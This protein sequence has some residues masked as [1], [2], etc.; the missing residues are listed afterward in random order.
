MSKVFLREKKISKG[1]KS[2][3]LDFYPPIMHPETRKP[4]RREHLK[5]YIYERPKTENEKEHNKET[6]MLG[7]AV[8]SQRQ[9]D[10]QSGYYGF[11]SA[12]NSRKNFIAFYNAF[13][14]TKRKTSKSNHESYVSIGQ[15]VKA[16]A[17]ENCTFA[18]VNE[19]F[20]RNFRQFLLD[21]E[22]ISNNTAAAYFDKFKYVIREAY[23]Q[24]QLRENPAENIKS[25]KVEGTKREF[26]IIEELQKLSETPFHYDDLRRA[27]LFAAMTGL[28]YCDIEKLIWKEIQNSDSEKLII[29]FQQKKT[30]DHETIPLNDDAVALLGERAKDDEQ[31]FKG[32]KYHQMKHLG[33]WVERAGIRRKITF[34]AFR[35]TFSFL[36]LFYGGDIYTLKDLLGHKNV[37]TTQVYAHLIDEKKREAVNKIKLR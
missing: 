13:T 5:L 23:T 22:T 27:S 1:R 30:K 34:H 25:I 9:L 7:D 24:K 6:K 11:L 21:Q 3:Y 28:R 4:T 17:G 14:E 32:L 36:H 29:R 8:R 2:L 26:L 15:Y 16:Y 12:R 20:C 33:E 10:I 37:K 19:G 35:H 31:V 18:E